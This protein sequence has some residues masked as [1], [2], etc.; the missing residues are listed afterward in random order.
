MFYISSQGHS[1]SAWLSRSLSTHPKVICWHGSRSI[2]PHKTTNQLYRNF[3]PLEF[4]L[5][6]KACEE[7]T[8]GQKIFGAIHGFH[9][10]KIKNEIEKVGG[11]FFSIFRHPYAKINSIFSAY[12]PS[13]LTQNVIKTDEI[14]INT[15]FLFKEIEDEINKKCENYLNY[16]KKIEKTKKII[17]DKNLLKLA[18]RLNNFLIK[19]KKIIL[20]SKK[21]NKKIIDL[22]LFSKHEKTNAAFETF[23]HACIRTFETDLELINNCKYEKCF[24]MEEFVSSREYFKEIFY[25]ITKFEVDEKQLD[26]V[27]S[28]N[29]HINTHSVKRTNIE[30]FNNWPQG[31]KD[32]VSKYLSNDKLKKFYEDKN[33]E[34]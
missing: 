2:P 13:N 24:V 34:F 29:N 6:L 20:K 14:K 17:G 18:Q 25:K 1:A 9:G 23:I 12:Y 26:I 15:Q 8:F 22:N 27:F 33:Y 31:F 3:N 16:R 4:A 32:I 30:I 21:K 5:G 11:N 7:N 10:I 19:N 28:N